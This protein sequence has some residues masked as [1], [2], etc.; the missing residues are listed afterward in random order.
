MS[1]PVNKIKK[2]LQVPFLEVITDE[3]LFKDAYDNLS[4]LPSNMEDEDCWAEFIRIFEWDPDHSL[5]YH[6]NY[7][8]QSKDKANVLGYLLGAQPFHLPVSTKYSVLLWMI[9]INGRI[10]FLELLANGELSVLGVEDKR[11]EAHLL[12]DLKLISQRLYD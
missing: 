8:N 1:D 12:T 9:S 3:A 7:S 5:T 11:Y 2:M 4:E 10:Y 6:Q